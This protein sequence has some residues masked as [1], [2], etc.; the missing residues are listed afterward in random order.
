MFSDESNDD[1]TLGLSLWHITFLRFNIFCL[2][3][4]LRCWFGNGGESGL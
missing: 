1:N 4:L 3:V 2:S